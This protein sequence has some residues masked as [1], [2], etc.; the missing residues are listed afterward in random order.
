MSIEKYKEAIY[1]GVLGK[2]IGVYLGR[3]VEGWKYEEIKNTFGEI[4]Y[5]IHDQVGLPLIVT[6]DDISG[7]FAFFRT[8][9]DNHYSKNITA[10]DIGN[11]WL[12]YIIEDKTILW[13]GGLGRSTEHTA[14]LR[15]KEGI[16]APLSGSIELNGQ[17]MAEQIGAQ[18]FIDAFAM[19]APGDPE[20]AVDLISKAASVSHDGLAVQAA[21]LLGAMESLAFHEKDLTRLLGEGM[22]YINSSFLKSLVEDVVNICSK[23]SDWRAVR[24]LL[25]EKYGYH[26][27]PG[28]CHIVPN[29][30]LI[31]AS[32]LLG[33]DDFQRSIMIATSAGW[34]TDC[35][36]GNVGCLN[37][38]RLGLAGIEQG[39]DFRGPVSDLLYVVSSDGGSCISDAVL[40]TRKIIKVAA[41]LKDTQIEVPAKRYGFEFKGS[42]Q[43][44]APCG[45]RRMPEGIISLSNLNETS[46]ENGLVINIKALAA[47]VSACVSTPVFIDFS[48]LV[49]AYA[50]I[51]S[52]TLYS[53]QTIVINI[54]AFAE[55][56]P[57]FRFYIL[58]YQGDNSVKRIDGETFSL[59]KG[60]NQCKWR[61]PDTGGMPIFRLGLEFL[62]KKKFDGKVAILDM[63]W[64]G[65]P[66]DF[67]QRGMLMTS[68]WD[69][70]PHWIAS[71]ASSAKQFAPDSKYTYCISHPDNNGVVTTGTLDW[72]DYSLESSLSFNLHCKGGLVIRSQ[73]HR[74]YYA[75]IF[76]H[77][78]KVSI[79]MRKDEEIIEL[80]AKEFPYREDRLYKVKLM[81]KNNKLTLFIDG[82]EILRGE[83]PGENYRNG[84][85]GFIVEKGTVLA[86]SFVVRA[87]KP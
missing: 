20:L 46:K 52:P 67:T 48:Q 50:A 5:Y 68:I 38:I 34:D 53:S 14:F 70:N 18:I 84:G 16:K 39:P 51:A 61:V 25:D 13:W 24:A 22:K 1:A 77:G 10:Q 35:N 86:D 23:E 62:A 78:K 15:L 32:L 76:S 65:A 47:G 85:G 71:W 26:K 63:D 83:D 66:A 31:I 6:D 41:A 36:A 21:C 27:F 69:L 57:D 30:A 19:S 49:Q 33:G 45:Y 7:T 79:I 54:K 2:I 64:Q 56:N 9:A 40:E 80:A 82:K 73:G 17:T 81:A 43:G 60:L 28:Q 29:H 87:M 75:G 3:P 11:T 55:R 58:F 59:Q 4:N 8:L 44:F 12:N 42:T 72:D 37:G 74:R